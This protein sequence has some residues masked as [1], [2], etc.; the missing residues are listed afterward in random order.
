M[1][2]KSK[3]TDEDLELLGEL[4]LEAEPEETTGRS[5][6][7]QRI[8][9]GFE[10]IERFY[11]EHGRSPDHGE[12]RDIFERIYAVRLNR[13][14]TSEECLAVLKDR[15]PRGLLVSGERPQI[16]DALDG[17]DESLL[18]SLGLESSSGDDITRI[19]HVRTTEE[20]RVAEEIAQR[21]VCADFSRFRS[22]FENV[23]LEIAAGQ[24]KV[25]PYKTGGDP[26]I[27]QGDWFILDGQKAFVAEAGKIFVAEYG[28]RDRRLRVI[29]DNK[30][31]SD[32]LMRSL[33]R[34]M[35]KDESSRRIM[36]RED[37]KG[38][39]FADFVADGD[40]HSGSIYVLRS[41]SNH[42]FVVEHRELIHKIGVTGQEVNIRLGNTKKE[43]T[44]LLADVELVAEYKLA[45]INRNA[46]ESMLHKVLSPA[47]LDLE[48]KDRFGSQVEPREWFL[49]PLAVIDEVISRIRDQSIGG[50]QYDR[51]TASL[52]SI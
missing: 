19:K 50:F 8:I 9:A 16:N 38:S 42:P 43:P 15:D 21:K 31:E 25:I 22:Q 18:A 32:L 3:V 7:E 14:R 34:A 37:E 40:S 45:N 10:E 20:R 24:R 17:D 39:L 52:T 44:Y 49:V 35:N 51:E 47:R 30:T 4:G 13:I 28:E 46:F 29:F 11:D 36:P 33:R 23:Q 41:R 26:S 5:P 2:K 6:R 12:D 1:A 27:D 48:L